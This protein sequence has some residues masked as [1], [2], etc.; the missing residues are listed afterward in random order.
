MDTDQVQNEHHDTTVTATLVEDAQ[1]CPETKAEPGEE[2]A[3]VPKEEN[4]DQPIDHP[5]AD[6]EEEEESKD[7]LDLPMLE[8]LDSLHLLTEWQFQN[9]YRLRQLMKDDDDGANW[10]CSVSVPLRFLSHSTKHV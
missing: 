2:Y 7:W 10:V 5:K 3:K 8:K 1:S 6:E 4:D 9:P